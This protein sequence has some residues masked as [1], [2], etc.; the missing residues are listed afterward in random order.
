MLGYAQHEFGNY[1]VQKLIECAL[2]LSFAVSDASK[3]AD[4]LVF[5]WHCNGI[6]AHL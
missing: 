4:Q 2:Q 6:V 1:V 5:V 3:L